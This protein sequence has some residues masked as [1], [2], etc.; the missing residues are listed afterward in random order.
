VPSLRKNVSPVEEIPILSLIY[1]HKALAFYCP[2]SEAVACLRKNEVLSV[3][4]S[5]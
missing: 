3:M 1:V 4:A 5:V 2:Y